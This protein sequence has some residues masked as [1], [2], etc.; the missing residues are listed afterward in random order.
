MMILI[1]VFL[2]TGA[3]AYGASRIAWPFFIVLISSYVVF[4]IS[5]LFEWVNGQMGIATLLEKSWIFLSGTQDLNVIFENDTYHC[6]TFGMS[7]LEL[8]IHILPA[9]V[10]MVAA[11]PGCVAFFGISIG[12]I[13]AAGGGL[14]FLATRDRDAFELGAKILAVA[15]IAIPIAGICL[16]VAV[17]LAGV[18]IC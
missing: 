8:V 16:R 2:V 12:T 15:L 17:I 13:M 10:L 14:I 4:Y 18:E 5:A 9:L 1:T 3:A 6:N 7:L 11:I